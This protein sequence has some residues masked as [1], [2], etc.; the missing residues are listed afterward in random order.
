MN[1]IAIQLLTLFGI[2]KIK[3]A[4]G[5]VA[6]FTTCLIYF[7]CLHLGVHL[8]TLLVSFFII[9]IISIIFINKYSSSFS[10]IDSKEIVIDEYLGQSIPI[11]LLYYQIQMGD[12]EFF[13]IYLLIVFFL[14]RV[15][16][17]FKPFPINIIDKKMKNG[18]GVVLDDVLAGVY[19]ILTIALLGHVFGPPFE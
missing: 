7:I 15:F 11:L 14:F 5:T 6:S 2:G 10:E 17:I 19:V 1:N 8:M 18:F 16:D 12:P 9:L 13:W 3:Y 4:P